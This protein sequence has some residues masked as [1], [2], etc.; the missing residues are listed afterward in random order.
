LFNFIAAAKLQSLCF[1][2]KQFVIFF[3][4]QMQ[5]YAK[6]FNSMDFIVYLCSG[7]QKQDHT[8]IHFFYLTQTEN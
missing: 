7:F 8:I 3:A 2:G 6:K 1:F 4:T 5:K